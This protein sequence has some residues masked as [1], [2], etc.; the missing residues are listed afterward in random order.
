M[1]NSVNSLKY[2]ALSL[3]MIT[4]LNTACS[5]FG[6]KSELEDPGFRKRAVNSNQAVPLPVEIAKDIERISEDGLLVYNEN[7]SYSSAFGRFSRE[8]ANQQQN[9]QSDY[10]EIQDCTKFTEEDYKNCLL[11]NEQIV[12]LLSGENGEGPID[13]SSDVLSEGSSV[14]AKDQDQ[15]QNSNNVLSEDDLMIKE[16]TG[17]LALTLKKKKNGPLNF[18]DKIS[19]SGLEPLT[20]GKTV[21]YVV[22]L[23]DTLMKIA[24]EKYANYLRW[25][26]IYKIN[27]NKMSTPERM[28]VGT[29]LTIKN[30]KYVYIKRDGKPYLIRKMDTLKSI[31]QKLYGTPNRWEEIWKNNPQL[32]RNPKKIYAGFTLYYQKPTK[33]ESVERREPTSSSKSSEGPLSGAKGLKSEQNGLPA[34][35]PK[36]GEDVF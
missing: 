14:K 3:V 12:K 15:N 21:S 24:F 17:P 34:V 9:G 23:G 10:P 2:L 1:K 6:G 36:K 33:P 27:K 18:R 29:E 32:V 20:G 7:P 11:R 28:Q 22:R 5:S 19:G 35:L 4:L 8:L 30:V 16:E 26:D 25:K 13:E 31:S